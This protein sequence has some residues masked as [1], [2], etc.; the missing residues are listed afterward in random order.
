M[1]EVYDCANERTIIYVIGI[2]I[3]C[4]EVYMLILVVR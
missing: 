2:R 4:C 3:L 1:N